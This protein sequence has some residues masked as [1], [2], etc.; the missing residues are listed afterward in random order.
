MRSPGWALAIRTGVSSKVGTADRPAR[1][2]P[3]WVD[4]GRGHLGAAWSSPAHTLAS[5]FLPP[6]V[7]AR[8]RLL[9]TPALCAR[10]GGLCFGGPGTLIPQGGAG[11]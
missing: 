6:E 3:P 4:R 11:L 8:K 2:E 1:R 10:C 9:F 7:G 5:D